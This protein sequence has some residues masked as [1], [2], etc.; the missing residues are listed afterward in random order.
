MTQKNEIYKCPLCANIIEVLHTGS[1]QLVCCG[2]PMDLL[3]ENS[4]DAAREKHVPVVEKV[5]EGFKVK[6]GAVAHPMTEAHHIE[7]IEVIANNKIYRQDL[8]VGAAPEAT[9]CLQADSVLARAYCNL[10]GL[11]KN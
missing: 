2:Q 7:W 4:V 1:G 8:A 9:F 6:V 5:A 10:H 3:T 11:W